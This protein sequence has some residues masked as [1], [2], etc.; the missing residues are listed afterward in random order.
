ERPQ[1][2]VSYHLKKLKVAG[3]VK[4]RKSSAD[5]RDIYYSLSFDHLQQ[6]LFASGQAL[7]PG[8]LSK[9]PAP[10]DIG[11]RKNQPTTRV[12]FLCT[13]NSARSQM[14]EGIFR[15]KSSARFAVFSAGD[16]VSEVHPLAIQAAAEIGF[17]ISQQRSKHFKIFENNSFD[18]IITVC[19]QVRETCPV[20]PGDPLQI[21]WS[22]P[23]P[24]SVEGNKTTRYHAFVETGQELESRIE[25][26]LIRL[27]DEG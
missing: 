27:R 21:H 12:L 6:V 20:F 5:R 19:D 14:A 23:D 18:H 15:A 3:L 11:S 10:T 17:D 13:H 4:E 1:N 9:R 25:Q 8:L 24:V 22:L 16:I 26:F 7:H 2:L